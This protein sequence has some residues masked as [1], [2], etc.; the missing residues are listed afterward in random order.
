M[1]AQY[2]DIPDRLSPVG[3]GSYLFRYEIKTETVNGDG[4]I[5]Y[6]CNEV[7]FQHY[8]LR[9]ELVN[10]VIREKYTQSAAEAIL[11]KKSLGEG[12]IDFLKFS[13]YVK[14]AK[15]IADNNDVTDFKSATV[16][17]IQIPLNLTFLGKD[18][19][20]LADKSLKL[21][22]PF[23]SIPESNLAISYPAWLSEDDLQTL[24]ADSR[25]N[26]EI[27]SIWDE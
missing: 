6:T 7:P 27:I 4:A 23:E 12:I 16:Y 13:N 11:R 18:Y 25:I 20:A 10:A 15:A 17:K 14:Y 21:N 1:K 22:I 26:I 5:M 19:A 24:A 2:N 8:P 3:N 9:D